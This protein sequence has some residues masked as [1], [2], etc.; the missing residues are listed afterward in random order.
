MF[1]P[2]SQLSA[3]QRMQLIISGGVKQKQGDLLKGNP[4]DIASNVVRY[5]RDNKLLSTGKY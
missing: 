3:E 2:D 1:T 5:F 4:K